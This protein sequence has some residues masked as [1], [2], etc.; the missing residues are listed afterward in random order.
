VKPDDDLHKGKIL[1]HPSD[2]SQL[3]ALDTEF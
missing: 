2:A 3:N 1:T